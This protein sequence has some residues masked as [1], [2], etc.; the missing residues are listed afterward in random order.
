MSHQKFDGHWGDGQVRGCRVGL[1]KPMTYMNRSG[2]SVAAAVGFYKIEPPDVLVVVDDL[3]LR[4]G[5]L[6]LR[7]RGSA[8]GHKGLK[9]CI[10]KLGGEE[11]ARLRI[12]IGAPARGGAVDYVL[13]RPSDD[14]AAVLD[15]AIGRAADAAELWIA[16]GPEKAMN[17]VNKERT[18]E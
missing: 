4:P 3:D 16:L 10:D 17:E 18:V 2:Q 9:D 12:G 1:L 14:E 6:R 7:A 13:S 8:G 15:A 11:F 5:Q